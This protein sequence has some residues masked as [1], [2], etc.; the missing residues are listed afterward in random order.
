[1]INE[2]EIAIKAIEVNNLSKHFK[3]IKAVDNIDFSVSKGEVFGFLGPNGVG[4]TTTI[5]ML[6]GVLK[7]TMGN[8]KI[9][10]KDLWKNPIQV[11][12]ILGN[13]PEMANVYMDLT[14]FQNLHFIGEMYGIPKNKRKAVGEKLLKQFQLFEKADKK[15]KTYSKGMKQRLLLCMA[16]MCDPKILFLDEPTSGLDVQSSIVIKRIIKEYNKNGM[17]IFLTTH[18]MNV[19]NELCTRI[20]II[21]NGRIIRLDTPENIKNLENKHIIIS[22]C[23]S[24]EIKEEDLKKIEGIEIIKNQKN[25][26]QFMLQDLNEGLCRIVDFTR[27]NNI[28]IKKINTNEPSLEEIFIKIIEEGN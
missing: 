28:K 3:N 22:I 19:A 15:T 16:L 7:P 25:T 18:N 2:E 9:F 20:A 1:M 8:I 23:F 26:F 6:T 24:E 10:N 27:N 14:G 5:R 4:K 17:T 13:V 21:N 11:K 12:E